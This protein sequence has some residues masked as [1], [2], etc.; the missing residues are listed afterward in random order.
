LLHCAA[1]LADPSGIVMLAVTLQL[2][3]Y[4]TDNG[5]LC[6]ERVELILREVADRE[7]EILRKR[8]EKEEHF[9][10]KRLDIAS[11]QTTKEHLRMIQQC[12]SVVDM[13]AI[14]GNGGGGETS[15]KR[16]KLMPYNDSG[17]H[18]GTDIETVSVDAFR[19]RNRGPG[20]VRVLQPGVD[21]R[22]AE[23]LHLFD[24]IREFADDTS[25]DRA[26]Q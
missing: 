10:Q 6:L 1:I 12:T 26:P 25:L 24:K 13:Q 20:G 16:A 18:A 19:I 17:T 14:G 4:I 8:I 23:K 2:G 21:S 9:A 5:E 3:G 11:K 7:N 15:A 22:T